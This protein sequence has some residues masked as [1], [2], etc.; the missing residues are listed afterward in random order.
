MAGA[1]AAE[2]ARHEALRKP[3]IVLEADEAV[4]LRALEERMAAANASEPV[5]SGIPV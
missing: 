4:V 5:A 2:R 3:P 1:T